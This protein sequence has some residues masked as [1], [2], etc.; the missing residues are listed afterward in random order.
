MDSVAFIPHAASSLVN[1]VWSLFISWSIWVGPGIW[2]WAV[3]FLGAL[4]G[5]FWIGCLTQ[6]KVVW[7]QWVLT[8][9]GVWAI[10]IGSWSFVVVPIMMAWTIIV[11]TNWWQTSRVGHMARGIKRRVL[12]AGTS[13]WDFVKVPNAQ[14]FTLMVVACLC[15]VGAYVWYRRKFYRVRVREARTIQASCKLAGDILLV[16]GSLGSII[17][18]LGVGNWSWMGKLGDKLVKVLGRGR[19]L[20]QAVKAVQ[21][22]IGEQAFVCPAGSLRTALI[23]QLNTN[24]GNVERA[25]AGGGSAD[26][27]EAWTS[28]R[29]ILLGKLVVLD[30]LTAYPERDSDMQDLYCRSRFCGG[31]CGCPVVALGDDDTEGDIFSK[32]EHWEG[33]IARVRAKCVG[34]LRWAPSYL[35]ALL[36]AIF[37]V[38]AL[39][40]YWDQHDLKVAEGKK[41]GGA[42]TRARK[43]KAVFSKAKWSN[44]DKAWKFYDGDDDVRLDEELATYINGFDK[45]WV[46]ARNARDDWRDAL[47]EMPDNDH[48]QRWVDD[49]SARRETAS[50]GKGKKQNCKDG[51][52]CKWRSISNPI[53][54]RKCVFVH[55]ESK[56]ICNQGAKCPWIKQENPK[57]GSVCKYSHPKGETFCAAPQASVTKKTTSSVVVLRGPEE[58]GHGVR[59]DDKNGH[60]TVLTIRHVWAGAEEMTVETFSGAKELLKV[61]TVTD[62]LEEKASAEDDPMV[63]VEFARSVAGATIAAVDVCPDTAF[64]GTLS[65][66]LQGWQTNCGGCEPDGDD[67][68]EQITTADGW[69]GTPLMKGNV[70]VGVHWGHLDGVNHAWALRQGVMHHFH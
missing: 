37:L 27:L 7:A 8:V 70:V 32:T 4:T 49:M 6:R 36:V 3:S 50:T 11:Q 45:A 59:V 18:V 60:F 25:L 1:T 64:L 24:L 40:K 31:K 43:I 30:D 29:D 22:N 53:W 2:P 56:G 54:K 61:V 35:V 39:L 47:N 58:M 42:A 16:I 23:V 51:A 46:D 44:N 48:F 69:S 52:L 13:V 14:D 17:G 10:A 62:V 38:L 63:L 9:F 57:W 55:P 28:D 5:C 19:L 33:V 68:V 26:D 12:A 15:V 65:A 21:E 66:K 67:I 41:R 20:G 34:V